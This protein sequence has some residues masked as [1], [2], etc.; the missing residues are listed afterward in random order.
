MRGRQEPGPEW[1]AICAHLREELIKVCPLTNRRF[2]NAPGTFRRAQVSVLSGVS[3]ANIRRLVDHRLPGCPDT[4]VYLAQFLGMR[5]LLERVGPLP[6]PPKP[7]EGEG[8]K[9]GERVDKTRSGK[10]RRSKGRRLAARSRS[11]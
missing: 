3:L 1:R 4:V 7:A 5:V 8:Y 9:Y 10:R 6:R 2:D 11:R